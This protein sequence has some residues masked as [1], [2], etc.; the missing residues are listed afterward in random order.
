MEIGMHC[1]NKT[2]TNTVKGADQQFQSMVCA[3][4]NIGRVHLEEAPEFQNQSG[5]W[6]L[7]CPQGI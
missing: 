6:H 2:A 5:S 3:G 1:S 7:V 4:V